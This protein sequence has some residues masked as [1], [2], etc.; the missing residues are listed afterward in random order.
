MSR[1]FLSFSPLMLLASLAAQSHYHATCNGAQEVPPVVSPAV[2]KG[3]AILNVNNTLTYELNV[4]GLPSAAI[5]S[6]IHAG[7]LGIAGPLLYTLT[8]T[9]GTTWAGTTPVLTAAEITSLNAG[10]LYMAIHTAAN[11]NGEVR[12]QLIPAKPPA[13]FGVG[14][15]G[16]NALVPAI[17]SGHLACISMNF[18]IDLANAR[19]S[20]VALLFLG[21]S[22][23]LYGAL[24]LPFNLG[25]IGMTGCTLYCS[26][27]GAGLSSATSA[28]G[29]GV[30]VIPIPFSTF[31]IGL[32]LYS[33]WFV[34]DPGANGLNLVTSDALSYAIK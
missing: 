13:K 15:V 12:G 27:L 2:A 19:A 28:T 1:I 10:N 6:H 24:P 31:L 3:R 23:T 20:S 7:A 17:S 29:T 25:I 16:T 11:P 26:D 32:Q 9:S 4:Q 34:V 33:Q 8:M 21:N 22:N 18:K 14:C 30:V 5:F